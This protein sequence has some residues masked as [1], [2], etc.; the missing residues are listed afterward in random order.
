MQQDPGY[1]AIP[2]GLPDAPVLA[3]RS[4]VATFGQA[5]GDQRA[6][7]AAVCALAREARSHDVTPERLLVCLKAAWRAETAGHAPGGD[8]HAEAELLDRMVSL[9]IREYFAP[10]R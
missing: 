4:A 9:C 2:T 8:R 5:S 6:L 1:S 10:G 3:V 7:H